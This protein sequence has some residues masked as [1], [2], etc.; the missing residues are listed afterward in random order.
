MLKPEKKIQLL[1]VTEKHNVSN[2]PKTSKK[3]HDPLMR[4]N[5]RIEKS[6]L[7]AIKKRAEEED[8][9]LTSV[10]KYCIKKTLITKN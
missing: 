9:T 10:I 6:V 7:N 3:N 5:L 8:R 1:T 2:N 4:I